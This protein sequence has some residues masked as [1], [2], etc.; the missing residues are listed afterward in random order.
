MTAKMY[1]MKYYIFMTSSIILSSEEWMISN[2]P[3]RQA[4]CTAYTLCLIFTL[5]YIVCIVTNGCCCCCNL[6]VFKATKWS[7]W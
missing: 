1:M 6:V 5:I 4:A 7:Q 3:L 2:I